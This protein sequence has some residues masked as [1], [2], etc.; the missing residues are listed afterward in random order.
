MPVKIPEADPTTQVSAAYQASSPARG[1]AG[2]VGNLRGPAGTCGDPGA[3]GRS[4]YGRTHGMKR[5]FLRFLPDRERISNNRWLRWIGPRLLHPRMWH[6]SRR[7]VAIGVGLGVFFGLL[8]PVAQIPFAAGMAV[9]L[10]A[11]VPAAVGSTLITNPFTFAPI[12]VLAYRL[13]ATLLG[14]TAPSDDE[15]AGEI[16]TPPAQ[17][18]DANWISR[19]WT[20]LSSLGKPLM[21]GLAIFATAFGFLIY[22]LISLAW[23]LKTTLTW[24]NRRRRR[25]P[26]QM[27]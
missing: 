3:R 15:I 20:G 27:P 26:M 22:L 19:T 21:L 17:D 9:V 23:R 24:Q 25:R 8:I 13:G 5:W 1:P 16:L 10:R 4:R 6:F 2:T 18:P 11:N 7:G 12:Y 14:E